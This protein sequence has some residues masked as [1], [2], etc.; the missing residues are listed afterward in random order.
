MRQ[1]G[2]AE[3]SLAWVSGVEL[4]LRCGALEDM[5]VNKPLL[6]PT[7][8]KVH[9]PT[10]EVEEAGRQKTSLPHFL[11]QRPRGNH[12]CVCPPGPKLQCSFGIEPFCE[13]VC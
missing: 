11:E 2:N 7:G 12:A 10:A 4:Q 13:P 6:E 3:P 9:R 5:L 8:F 1:I